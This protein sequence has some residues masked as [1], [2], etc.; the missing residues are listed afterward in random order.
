MACTGRY[1]TA[2]QYATLLCLDSM[3]P[4]EQTTIERFLDLAAGFIHVARSTQAACNCTVAAGVDTYLAI[5]NVWIAAVI[6]RC[7]CGTARL[8]DAEKASWL[9][10]AQSQLEAI[11][12]GTLELCQGETGTSFPYVTWAEHSLTDWAAAQIVINRIN[13]YGA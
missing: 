1:A 13:R 6:N 12:D 11:R 2:Q 7:P 8:T 5:L 10:W 9:Q 4:S 3:T